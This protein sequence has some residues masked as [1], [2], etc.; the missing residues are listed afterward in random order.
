MS[1]GVAEGDGPDRTVRPK[2]KL[3]GADAM[4]IYKFRQQLEELPTIEEDQ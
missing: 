2:D 1:G 3:S 4:T